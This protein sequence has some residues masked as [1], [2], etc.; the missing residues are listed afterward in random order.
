[1][2]LKRPSGPTLVTGALLVLLPALA[3]L[4]YRWVGQVSTAERERM[5]RNLRNA[6]AQF[7]EGFDGEIARAV[8]SLQVGPQTAQEGASDR[9]TDRYDTWLNT[10]AHPQVVAAIFL[11]DEDHGLRL[12]R[13]NADSHTFDMTD[14]PAVLADPGAPLSAALV[15]L[16]AHQLHDVGTAAGPTGVQHGLSNA[17]AAIAL[18]WSRRRATTAS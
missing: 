15:R 8:I 5:Q 10:A 1:M 11:L 16:G 17:S 13:W 4:Q 9:Y 14:W 7:R 6:A 18:S 3:V 2:T 12:R